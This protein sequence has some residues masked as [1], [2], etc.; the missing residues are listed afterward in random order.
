MQY[1]ETAIQRGNISDTL[2]DAIRDRIVD[3]RLAAGERV[4]EVHLARMLGVS[5]TPLREALSRLTQEGALISTPRIGFSVKPLTLEEFGQLYN[6][7]PIL[8][9]EALRL[10]GLPDLTQ[11]E[12]LQA[13]NAKIEKARGANVVIALDDA[14]HVELLAHCPNKILL[15]LIGQFIRRTRRY[16]IALMRERS[17]VFAASFDHRVIMAALK[18]R[19]LPGACAA[20]RQNLQTAKAPI[21]AWLAERDGRK[22]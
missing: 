20:L 22:D 17:N 18:R 5:R 7:R 12:R 9:P 16:E 4:N 11:L 19:D 2:A 13:L 3:G 14:W 6:I 8:D 15:E 21:A 1:A 10:A